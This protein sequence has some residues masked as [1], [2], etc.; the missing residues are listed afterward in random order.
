M[1]LAIDPEKPAS[2]PIVAIS[3]GEALLVDSLGTQQD[4]AIGSHGEEKPKSS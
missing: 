1:L 4:E 3:F 2:D